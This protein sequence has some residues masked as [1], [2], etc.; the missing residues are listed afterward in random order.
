MPVIK[1][2]ARVGRLYTQDR[3]FRDGSWQSEQC[4]VSDGRGIFDLA[5]LQ[6][7][8]ILSAKGKA[9]ECVLGPIGSELS[10][11]KFTS[12]GNRGETK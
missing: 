2:D 8:F 6:T 1:Y 3:V 9:P 10:R 7:G 11:P 5:N 4:D 12:L